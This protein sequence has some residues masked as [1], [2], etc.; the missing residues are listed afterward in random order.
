MQVC[1]LNTTGKPIFVKEIG[2]A[3]GAKSKSRVLTEFERVAIVGEYPGL[4]FVDVAMETGKKSPARPAV[5]D[6]SAVR[7]ETK[8][9]QKAASAEDES[10]KPKRKPLR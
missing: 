10:A 3:V 1:L 5:E 6:D 2:M 7:P 8:D 9:E 4:R